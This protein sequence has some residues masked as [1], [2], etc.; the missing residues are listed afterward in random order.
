MFTAFSQADASTSRKFGGT[1]LGLSISKHLVEKMGG[2]IGVTSQEGTGSTFWFHIE[3]GKPLGLSLKTDSQKQATGQ[4]ALM[5]L[6]VLVAEDN[7]VNQKIAVKMLEKMGV[8]ADVVVNGREVLKAIQAVPYDLILM[9][10]QMP[11][12]DGYEVTREIRAS[13]TGTNQKMVIVAMTANAFKGDKEKCLECG[14]NDYV[15]KPVKAPDLA[16]MI[17]KWAKDSPS[18]LQ[19]KSDKAG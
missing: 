11:E 17:W 5:G 18:A 13:K 10:C 2:K 16:A 3:L 14:M 4:L 15:S 8:Q 12:M 19:Q 7:I 9:D 1:G 6:R